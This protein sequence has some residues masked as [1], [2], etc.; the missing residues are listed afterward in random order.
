MNYLK[1]NLITNNLAAQAGV[2]YSI[3]N[4]NTSFKVM[5]WVFSIFCDHCKEYHK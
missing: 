5:F 2:R 3:N 4:P 1:I